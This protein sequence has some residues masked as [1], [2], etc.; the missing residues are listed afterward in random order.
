VWM[1][2]MV[3]RVLPRPIE[4]ART[5]PCPAGSASIAFHTNWTDGVRRTDGG[6]RTEAGGR[7][8]RGCGRGCE[9]ARRA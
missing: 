9:R 8:E 1:R 4:W 6:G 3:V 5:A 2:A 7:T